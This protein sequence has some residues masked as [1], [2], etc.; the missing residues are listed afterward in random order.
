MKDYPIPVIISADDTSL[1]DEKVYN[2]I[3]NTKLQAFD[4]EKYEKIKHSFAT[5]FDTEKF[6]RAV[7]ISH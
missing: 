4:I 3:K 6:L 5:Y 2:I 1:T 7:G